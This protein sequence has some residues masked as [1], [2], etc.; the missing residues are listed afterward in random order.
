MGAYTRLRLVPAS[1]PV[2]QPDDAFIEALFQHCET[3]Q[4]QWVLGYSEPL[5]WENTED[6]TDNPVFAEYSGI[7][8]AGAMALCKR[9]RPRVC[10]YGLPF[11]PYSHR[12]RDAL[13]AIP[14]EL[15]E[16]FI[17]DLV[18]ITVGPFS[19]PDAWY[20]TTIGVYHFEVGISG[21]GMPL[22]WDEYVRQAREVAPL[23]ELLQYLEIH[24]GKQFDML[25]SSSY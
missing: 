11:G 20:E 13:S 22:D 18:D 15:R 23:K 3:T 25:I 21:Q 6:V 2:W 24:S 4:V 1:D 10:R 16:G 12:I 14:K 5:L 17:P 19:I 9:H 8:V 7:D